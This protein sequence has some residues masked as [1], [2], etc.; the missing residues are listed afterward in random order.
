M[1]TNVLAQEEVLPAER[2]AHAQIPTDPETRWKTVVPVVEDL[3][4]KAKQLGLW[5][6]FLSKT[7]YPKH[8]VPLT[9]LEVRAGPPS[10]VRPSDVPTV[11]RY[12]RS[13]RPR[14]AYGIRGCQLCSTGYWKYG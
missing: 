7:H 1:L 5:N 10:T 2:I 13:S 14:R 3:K 6:L 8:G 4:A 12:G 9:N 11:C